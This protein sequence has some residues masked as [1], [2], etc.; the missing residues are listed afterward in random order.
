MAMG[1]PTKGSDLVSK[2]DASDAAK[3]KVR[4]VLETLS[5]KISVKEAAARLDVTESRFHQIRDQILLGML[6]AAEPKAAG[7]PAEPENPAQATVEHL[8]ARIRELSSELEISQ[9]RE[10]LAFA[11][12]ELMSESAEERKKKRV[13]SIITG[14]PPSAEKGSSR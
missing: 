5:A 8:Q 11:C 6:N 12:P 4:L 14:Q 7:R 1:R 10:V 3:E 2:M 9:L 13:S